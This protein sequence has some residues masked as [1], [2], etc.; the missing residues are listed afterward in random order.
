VLNV[1][2]GTRR[3]VVSARGFRPLYTTVTVVRD[4]QFDLRGRLERAGPAASALSVPDL[5]S[6]G[7]LDEENLPSPQELPD[8][9]AFER[10]RT[11]VARRQYDAA[12]GELDAMAAG[13][14]AQRQALRIGQERRFIRRLQELTAAAYEQLKHA[15]GQD[16]VLRLRKG[17]RLTGRLGA[18]TDDHAKIA[19]GG[20]ER[21]I[22]LESIAA[23]QIVRLAQHG[24]E[25]DEPEDRVTFALLH[26]AEGEFD[27]A[28]NHLRAAARGGCEITAARTHVDAEHLWAAAVQ[29]EAADL[30]RARAAGLDPGPAVRR[31]SDPVPL[32]IGTHRGRQPPEALAAL[33][34]RGGFAVRTLARPFA[35]EDGREPA[36]LL[37]VD[38]GVGRPVPAFDRQEVQGIVDLVQR[39]GGLVFFGAARPQAAR[40]AGGAPPAPH[41]YAPLL[42]WFGIAVRADRLSVDEEAPDGYPGQWALA[43]PS[44]PHAVTHRVR[45]AVFPIA[46][47]SL[48]AEDPSWV[49][50]RAPPFVRSRQASE[51]APALVAGRAFGRGR[52]LVFANLPHPNRS[53]WE[54]SP[55]GANDAESLVADGLAWVSAPARLRRVGAP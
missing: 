6:L 43:Y 49:L 14:S 30:L 32:L 23:E 55:L 37:I 40:R 25:P 12:L 31:S 42:G 16:Y 21:E 38:A 44:L 45:Q 36:V 24:L 17:V 15:E 50:M 48:A 41:P 10:V 33:L 2:A 47:P 51:A 13:P 34:A 8:E 22:P 28:Y 18:V 3:V 46:S 52:V 27:D 35:A 54:G 26:A 7:V 9:R 39:G 29:K 11:L 20:A 19:I 1:P 4:Q 53:A 5:D